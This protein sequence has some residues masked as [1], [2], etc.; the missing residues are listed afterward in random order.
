MIKKNNL[1]HHRL[2]RE[3]DLVHRL[4]YETIKH[5]IAVAD[6]SLSYETNGKQCY[7]MPCLLLLCSRIDA[8]GSYYRGTKEPRFTNN[9]NIST[10]NSNDRFHTFFNIEEIKKNFGCLKK[11]NIETIYESFRCLCT[12]NAS[13]SE[14]VGI[15]KNESNQSLIIER[16]DYMIINLP[17]LLCHVQIAFKVLEKDLKEI[18]KGIKNSNHPE[19]TP[20]TATTSSL[21]AI[22]K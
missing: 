16:N 17:V 13:L 8:I 1:R 10:K 6:Y 14:K 9:G 20:L 11:G 21:I 15:I 5:Y 12:H 4:S 22:Y 2:Y 3:G 18:D 7:G 19:S